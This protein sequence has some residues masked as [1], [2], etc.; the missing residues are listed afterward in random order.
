MPQQAVGSPPARSQ[1]NDVCARK[2]GTSNLS[3]TTGHQPRPNSG[4]VLFVTLTTEDRFLTD[5]PVSHP[6][7]T[8]IGEGNRQG[9]VFSP[10]K[11]A[12]GS[13]RLT[14]HFSVFNNTKLPCVVY[15]LHA[16]VYNRVKEMK[17]PATAGYSM[18][19]QLSID[20]SILGQHAPVPLSQGECL[21]VALAV[22][23]S[24]FETLKTT[25]V[26]GLL[27]D[28]Y[29]VVGNAPTKR[30]VPS[31]ALY[32]FQHV[33][34]MG[35]KCHFV[36]RTAEQIRRRMIEEKCKSEVQES[37]RSLLASFDQHNGLAVNRI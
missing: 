33:E 32:V 16:K 11:L 8:I 17:V 27:V 19:V 13:W 7:A 28:C 34:P 12:R 14:V 37:C 18:A 5:D 6:E 22:E 25:V 21:N 20:N 24:L 3:K 35:S 31:D 29:T 9:G 26:F 2:L 4:S 30:S 15:D 1:G 36:S 10:Y 23:A